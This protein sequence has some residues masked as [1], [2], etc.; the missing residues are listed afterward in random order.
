MG[1]GGKFKGKF[2]S[3]EF[4][5][6]QSKSV[7]SAIFV[8]EYVFRV[9]V[10]AL[11]V[12]FAKAE[13]DIE[14]GLLFLVLKM[15]LSIFAKVLKIFRIRISYYCFPIYYMRNINKNIPEFLNENNFFCSSKEKLYAFN[16]K[17]KKQIN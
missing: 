2:K 14:F 17:K 1:G 7:E 8:W 9:F 10:L 3:G 11:V 13:I 15:N 5:A 12:T 16:L 6:A 4:R